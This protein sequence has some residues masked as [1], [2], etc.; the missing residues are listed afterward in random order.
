MS[1]VSKLFSRKSKTLIDPLVG[2]NNLY[3]L[4][5]LPGWFNN[6]SIP[7][8]TIYKIGTRK[9]RASVNET[10]LSPIANGTLYVDSVAGDDSNSG[11]TEVTAVATINEAIVR[12][13]GLDYLRDDFNRADES[14]P[15]SSDWGAVTAASS[16]ISGSQVVGSGTSHQI[17]RFETATTTA[18]QFAQ[19]NVT[20]YE[21]GKV[22]GLSL[23]NNESDS[24]YL[25]FFEN[26][27][28]NTCRVF[29][30]LSGTFT[31]LETVNTTPPAVP[32]TARAE[33]VSGVVKG[34][35]DGVEVISHTLVSDTLTANRKTGVYLNSA[36]NSFDDF[37][38]GDVGTVESD[39]FTI[40][41]ILI[42][43]GTYTL[44]ETLPSDFILKKF[45]SGTVTV[46]SAVTPPTG[47]DFKIEG[48]KFTGVLATTNGTRFIKDCFF[49]NASGEGLSVHGT[50][51]AVI[52]RLSATGCDDDVIDYGDSVQACEIGSNIYVNGSSASSNCSTAHDASRVVRVGGDYSD[53][54]RPIHDVS[55]SQSVNYGLT[56]KDS[57]GASGEGTSFL[58]GAG[59]NTIS[60]ESVEMGIFGCDMSEGGATDDIYGDSDCSIFIDNETLYSTSSSLA[61]I[62]NID[63]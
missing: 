6:W 51:K 29:S 15:D 13:R 32:F 31:L 2:A 39:E 22:V 36:S 8:V 21:S 23:R 37:V 16:N 10:D 60:S 56:V 55:T 12:A 20:A 40:P 7:E 18:D 28:S 61:D 35:I 3:D 24:C 63:D 59:F 1:I 14:L 50:G 58:M 52:L 54:P 43:P 47:S 48:I 38:A 46:T 17:G 19:V 62:T 27:T 44:T 25:V 33:I 26:D 11:L 30:Y 5:S 57:T 4:I 53:S 49:A 41:E 45:S 34:Y 42:K 9:Y